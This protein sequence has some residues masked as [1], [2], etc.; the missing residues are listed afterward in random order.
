MYKRILYINDCK[1]IAPRKE[2]GVPVKA[3]EKLLT[4]VSYRY[5]TA[6]TCPRIYFLEQGV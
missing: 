5:R 4:H 1:D 3:C 2:S 6:A